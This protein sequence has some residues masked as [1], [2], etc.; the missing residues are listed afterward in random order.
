MTATDPGMAR[1]VSP[2]AP[3]LVL[4]GV[5]KVFPG[6]V[7]LAGVDFDLAPGE[8]H[9]LAGENGAGKSTL[10]KI[11]A[12]VYQP[13]AG[14]LRVGGR[15]VR[16]RS[17]HD[18][19]AHGIAAIH[20]EMSLVGPMSVADNLF[21]GREMGTAGWV[22]SRRQLTAAG[23]L[24]A[25]LGL[26]IDP[27]RPVESYP[28]AVQQ[29]V[30]IAKALRLE[31]RILI[32]DE[33]TSA[34]TEP[35]VDRLFALI[36]S[37]KA[38]GCGIVYI[39]HRMEEIYRVADRITVLRD[40]AR[41]GTA[42][43][44][45]LPPAELVRWMVGREL[46]Q[47]F[48]RRAV[49][50]GAER[51]RVCGFTVPHRVRGLPPV[52]DGVSFAVHAGEILG[53]AGLQGSGAGE[54]LHGLFGALGTRPRGR[55]FL[56]GRPAAIR[57]PAQ[58]LRNGMALLTADRK[59]SGIV[60]GLGVLHNMTLASVARFSPGGWV[61]RRR[62]LEAGTRYSDELRVRAASLHQEISELSGGNQ[63]K[64][65]LARCRMAQPRV[66]LLDEPTRGI[67][68]GAKHDVYELMNRWTEAG[69]AV[70]LITSEMPELLAMADRILVLHRGRA[71]AL[72]EHGQATQDRVLRAAMGEPETIP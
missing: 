43:R 52:V 44:E 23:E 59:G 69:A 5:R 68:V 35:E 53:L 2:S 48:P 16:L 51:L 37:L 54:L 28:V 41:I 64:V 10:I 29:L 33:P 14:E 20:Q 15:P 39:S 24:L 36:A 63:Q 71:A 9:V 38:R 17:P 67:D 58:A 18:A 50:A 60:P 42:R 4:T 47:Q 32:M 62:E 31:A 45:S 30:E 6:T 7:A 70:V 3:L 57:S 1:A 65:L 8:V 22:A 13:D 19:A 25:Q 72:L 66:F 27:S 56:D 55:L 49:P 26:R 21:L 40:G 12:G 34:L 61:R 11:I 46:A